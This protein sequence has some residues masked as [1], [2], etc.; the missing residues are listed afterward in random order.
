[1]LHEGGVWKRGAQIL[2]KMEK[3]R[4]MEQ[5]HLDE[6]K[7]NGVVFVLVLLPRSLVLQPTC[8]ALMW[9]AETWARAEE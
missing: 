2:S 5:R 8:W 4:L 1:M 6:N 9:R 7:D 3:E